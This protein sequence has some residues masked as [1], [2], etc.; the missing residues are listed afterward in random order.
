MCSQNSIN[1]LG[2]LSFQ[3]VWCSRDFYMISTLWDLSK[4]KV[5][6]NIN[7][8]HE[9]FES[10]EAREKSYYEKQAIELVERSF[11][12]A[13]LT[14]VVIVFV[15]NILCLCRKN[16]ISR[17]V[18]LHE[19]STHYTIIKLQFIRNSSQALNDGYFMFFFSK[20][21]LDFTLHFVR[22]S[23]NLTHHSNGF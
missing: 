5:V 13:Y 18:V 8:A 23:L 17:V 3:N 22:P 11:I 15:I 4:T 10:M 19:L 7:A 1:H 14:D 16:V 12:W 9:S 20:I 6:D 21:F 2:N